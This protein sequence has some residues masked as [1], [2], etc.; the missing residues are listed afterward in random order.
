MICCCFYDSIRSPLK[1][2]ILS[3]V[4]GAS[5]AAGRFVQLHRLWRVS[6]SWVPLRDL[7]EA[8][9]ELRIEASRPAKPLI[10][11]YA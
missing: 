7:Q 2:A 1:V 11:V 10:A 9:I 8:A 3:C 5:A 6:L 4:L